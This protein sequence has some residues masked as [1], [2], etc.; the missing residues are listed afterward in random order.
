[1]RLLPMIVDWRDPNVAAHPVWRWT[2]STWWGLGLGKR[3]SP[4]E[5]LSALPHVY[6]K[7]TLTRS[8]DFVVAV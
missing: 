2:R 1:M 5:T 8:Q 4:A 7:A 3:A 6:T